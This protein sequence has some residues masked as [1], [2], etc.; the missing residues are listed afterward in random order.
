MKYYMP[1]IILEDDG[2]VLKSGDIFKKFGNKALIVTGRTSAKKSGALDDVC[3]VLK[4]NNIGYEIFDEV[5]E[6]PPIV[7]NLNGAELGSD[8]DFV[9]GIGGGSPLDTAKGI[10]VLI[11]HGTD[12]YKE[13]LF[14]KTDYDAVPVIAIPTTSGTGSEVTPYSV[15]TDDEIKTKTSMARRIFP[16]YSFIDVKYFE[17]M[18]FKVRNSTIIDAFTHAIES[19]INAKSTPYSEVFAFKAIEIFGKHRNE[20]FKEELDRDVFKDFIRASTFAGMA[21]A[22]TGTSLPHTMGYPLTYNFALPHGI[23]NAIFVEEFLKVSPKAYE[24]KILEL[25][26]FE[27]LATLGEYFRKINATVID[28]ISVED[29]DIN[30]YTRLLMANKRKL[31]NLP[32]MVSFDDVVG[33]YRGALE[34]WK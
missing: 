15:F 14:G 33:M 8:C 32:Q 9:I 26:G 16:E 22:Q 7:Q 25:T 19:F 20:L 4:E 24:K 12:D 21:I 2:I 18:P 1:S 34:A 10:A 11:K 13:K 6:N 3:S 29:E 27:D 28:K 17:T 23:A 30:E 5:I 31:A